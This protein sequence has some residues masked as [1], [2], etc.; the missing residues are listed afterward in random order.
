MSFVDARFG[1]PIFGNTFAFSRMTYHYYYY[2][3]VLLIILK[4]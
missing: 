1:S 4:V 3:I 2:F